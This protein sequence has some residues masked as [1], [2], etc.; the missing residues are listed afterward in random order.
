MK[1]NENLQDVCL[2]LILLC[3]TA[4]ACAAC[5]GVIRLTYDVFI[6]GF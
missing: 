3:M 2:G 4:A 5:V 1:T 6:K